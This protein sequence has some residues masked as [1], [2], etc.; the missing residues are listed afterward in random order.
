MHSLLAR[1]RRLYTSTAIPLYINLIL[2]NVLLVL[3]EWGQWHQATSEDLWDTQLAMNRVYNGPI[4]L[5]IDFEEASIFHGY[6]SLT[7][8]HFLMVMDAS[9]PLA[10]SASANVQS[11]I[12][13]AYHQPFS[14]LQLQ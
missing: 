6:L 11:G 5:S 10:A 9:R 1:G 14:I 2:W 12:Q 4:Q 13:P 3:L 7:A 8:T